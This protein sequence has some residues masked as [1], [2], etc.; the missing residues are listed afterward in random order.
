MPEVNDSGRPPEWWPE[1]EPWRRRPRWW[2][3]FPAL[4][5]FLALVF[6]AGFAAAVF[7]R[8]GFPWFLFWPLA[9]VAFIAFARSRRPRYFPVRR[10]VEAAEQLAAGDYRV[11]VPAPHSGPM[12]SVVD[13]FNGLAETLDRSSEQR[14]QLLADL[15]HELR[16]PL[17]VIQ[18][19]LEA[20]ADGVHPIDA[21]NLQMLLHETHLMTRLVEDLR[22]LSL[23][24]AGALKLE[25]ETTEVGDLLDEAV[26]R[27]RN[28]AETAGISIS[29]HAEPGTA[30][31]DPHRIR[32]VLA[33]LVTNALR[34]T[35]EGG[36]LKLTASRAPAG[37]RIEVSDTGPGISPEM[38]PNIFE[39]FVKGTDSRG[40]GLGLSIA[41]DLVRAHGGDMTARSG[42]QLPGRGTTIEFTLPAA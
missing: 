3:L 18:G 39:R 19:E 13:A 15:G 12:R 21:A 6:A 9:I 16:T 28:M 8:R 32:E 14:R 30:D 24:E 4:F 31:L 10:L 20:M 23:A 33:N 35:P 38:L 37:W 7:D 1:G 40:S 29:A 41:R 2:F 36:E 25:K 42:G 26:S 34:H 22:L 5:F 17:Q 11:R 27:Y